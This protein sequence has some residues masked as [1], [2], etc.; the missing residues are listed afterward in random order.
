MVV[1]TMGNVISKI[2]NLSD[3]LILKLADELSYKVGGFGQPITTHYLLNVNYK[4]T[5][6]GVIPRVIQFLNTYKIAYNLIDRRKVPTEHAEPAFKIANGFSMRDY[7]EKIVN[8]ASSR[9]IIQAATGAGKT[10]IMANL[11][12]KYNVKPVLVIAPKI[13]LAVQIR[14][15]FEKFLGIKICLLGGGHNIVFGDIIISTPQS[16][17]DNVISEAKMILFDETHFLPGKTIFQIASQAQNAYYRFGVSATPWRD[18][19]C[20]LLIEA[21]LNIRKPQLTIN[22]SQLIAKGKLTP[23]TI[24]FIQLKDKVKWQG[25]YDKT[26]EMAIVNNEERN[27]KII[28]IGAN[29]FNK[30]KTQ[31]I[32]IKK[33][34]HGEKLLNK[35]KQQLP[36]EEILN[37]DAENDKWITIGNIEFLSGKD[38]LV[39]R[40][41]VLQAVKNGFCKILIASTIADEGLDLPCLDTLILAGSGKSSTRAFQR[42][43]RV[44]RL[45]PGKTNAIVY[46]FMDNNPTFYK[47]ALVRK[48]LY[49]TEK[50]W[51][52]NII[53]EGN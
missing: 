32:L 18:D 13:S 30:G 3:E 47:H 45:Y 42:I 48:A 53:K 14:D 21:A 44:L 15:E 50:E 29:M 9:E 34:R 39:K 19:D 28:N 5:Y 12:V 1:I 25:S 46:D 8:N 33:I 52:I 7:Q 2:D 17:P 11:I 31:L 26:Y 38:D 24:N 6:T 35:F 37:Y 49:E 23:C 4:T 27:K 36:Y 22:A 40:N 20:D 41:A 43:G 16:C 10:F 51:K